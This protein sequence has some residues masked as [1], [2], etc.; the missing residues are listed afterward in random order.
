MKIAVIGGHGKVALILAG[1][2]SGR[3]DTVTSVIRNPEHAAD[4]ERAGGLPLLLDVE[5]ADE[6]ALAEALAG[7]DAVVWSAGAGGG[8][9]D[10]TYAV[11]RDAAV[12]SMNAARRAGVRRYVMVSFAGADVRHLVNQDDPFYPYMAAKIAAD[13]HLRGSGLDWTILG[14]GALTLEEGTG[15]VEPD[16]DRDGPT[17]TS[18]ANVA[19]A[20]VAALDEPGSIGRT[21]NF[22]D[23]DVP[24]REW[25]AAP[26]DGGRA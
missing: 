4:V 6:A 9:P 11:D 12:R 3:G 23:G 13:D 26:A 5:Q 8:N 10:R 20:V 7:H 2:L 17:E 16:P 1:L 15:R 25:M 21:L 14:P 19:L 18:R 22:R 24:L